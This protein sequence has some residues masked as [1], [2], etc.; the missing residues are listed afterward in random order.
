MS[1]E[2]AKV[3]VGRVAE[4]QWGRITRAQLESLGITTSTVS[5]WIE[6]GY[7][8]RVL[9]GVYAVGHRAGGYAADLS[10]ALLYAGPGAML[11][12]AT[13][14]HWLGLIDD[15]PHK[16]HISTPHRRRS[17]PGITVHERRTTERV[18]HN[19]LPTTTLPQTLLDLSATAPLR[20][21]R[22]ALAKADYR[23]I[24]NLPSLN[25]ALGRGRPGSTQLRKALKDHH[26]GIARARSDLE[27]MFIELCEH[28]RIPLPELNKRVAGWDVDALWR[29]ERIAV[30]LDGYDNH[31]SPAQVKRDRR[32]EMDL[33]TAGYTPVRYS[34]E[35]L[36]GYRAAVIDEIR[37]MRAG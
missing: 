36:T 27:V 14:A 28:A 2:S 35:Q 21:V 1:A 12:H 6:Q 19:Q 24:L 15:K 25:A 18:W 10:A 31:R 9:P 32:K 13:A 16:I 5:M 29:E 37:R 23:G 3:R 30:E 17:Q 34:E 4:R 26:P 8:H 20:T 33:R 7:L 11:S 22:K